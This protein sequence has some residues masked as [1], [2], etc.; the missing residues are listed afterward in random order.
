MLVRVALLLAANAVASS[1][2][3]ADIPVS[4]LSALESAQPKRQLGIT[5]Q[6]FL[7]RGFFLN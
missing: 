5:S 4:L 6:G 2:V 7:Y 3:K 1:A